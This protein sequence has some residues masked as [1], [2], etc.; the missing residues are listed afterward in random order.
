MSQTTLVAL[1][2]NNFNLIRG[3]RIMNSRIN[4]SIYLFILLF[5]QFSNVQADEFRDLNFKLFDAA[6]T[7]DLKKTKQLIEQGASIKAR[8]RIGNSALIYAAKSGSIKL[9]RY[10]VEQEAQ[11]N[12]VNT[13]GQSALMILQ[14]IY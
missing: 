10:L 3:L 2:L 6:K 4:I 14:N 13:R 5:L 11:I 7:G 8:N 1:T 12:M 9:V